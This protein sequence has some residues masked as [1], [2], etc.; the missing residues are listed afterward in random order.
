MQRIRQAATFLM[1]A[2]TGVL[3]LGACAVNPATGER[4][5]TGLLPAAQEAAIGAEQHPRILE[6][7]GGTL[8]DPAIQAYVDGIGQ[9]LAANTELPGVTYT[10]TVLDSD[11]VNAFALPGGYVYVTRGLMQL[12]NS[13]AQLA[14]VIGH[15]IGHITGRHAAER[16]S[17]GTLAQ[18]GAVAAAVLGGQ[19]LGQMAAQG[20]QLAVAGWGRGQELEADQLGIRYMAN[21][22]YE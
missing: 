5:F 19:E 1:A 4:Q 18:L 14:G 7:F 17:Q 13:E 9:R 22:G 2:V 12:A 3:L 16:Y 8:N 10:F 21:V 20:A 6:E 11:V 15:E